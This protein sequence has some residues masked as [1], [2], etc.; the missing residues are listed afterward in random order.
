M[1]FFRVPRQPKSCMGRCECTDAKCP[2]RHDTYCYKD[3]TTI[4]Y[5]LDMDDETGTAMCDHCAED[6]LN[7]GV[8]STGEGTED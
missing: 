3:A 4:V 1:R 6:A 7:S 8:F 2:S 5:R